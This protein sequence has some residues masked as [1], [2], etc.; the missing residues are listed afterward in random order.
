MGVLESLISFMYP[1]LNDFLPQW[2]SQ[3]ALIFSLF[4]LLLLA[5]SMRILVQFLPLLEEATL[6]G[7][8]SL[9]DVVP[10]MVDQL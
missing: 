9:A 7:G 5:A 1:R 8:K 2:T 3:N 4:M 6:V 10:D